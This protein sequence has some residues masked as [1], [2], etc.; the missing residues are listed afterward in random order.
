MTETDITQCEV[1]L[2]KVINYEGK[3]VASIADE[4]D[5]YGKTFVDWFGFQS[6]ELG[7]EVKGIFSYDEG[8]IT[9]VA[10]QAAACGADFVI[11]APSKI[12][13]IADVVDAF[14]AEPKAPRLLFSDMGYGVD[15]LKRLGKKA[16]GIEGVCLGADPESGFDVSYRSYFGTTPTVGTAQIYDAAMLLAYAAWYQNMYPKV[17][18]QTALRHVVDGRDFLLGSWMSEDMCN[19]INDMARG[20]SPDVKGASG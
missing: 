4:N 17:T 10:K 1:L 11:C 20:G 16:E 19:V 6:K 15:V 3:S 13:D 18:L 14:N 12:D 2:S 5:S 7:L 8:K 9:D